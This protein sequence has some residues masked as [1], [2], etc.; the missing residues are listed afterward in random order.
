MLDEYRREY[1]V[2]NAARLR[3]Q[4]LFLSGQKSNLEIAPIYERYSDLFST[5]SINKLKQSLEATPEH[6][7]TERASLNRLLAFAA[8]QFLE[9]SVKQL[10]EAIGDY[11]AAATIELMNREMTFQET[12]A[13]IAAEPDRHE[14]LAIYKK[15]L[16]V[17]DA[18]NHL[19]AERLAKLRE[20][21]RALGYANY[22]SLFEQLR[23]IDYD[24][25]SREAEILL[26]RTESLYLARLDEA[27][28]RSLGIRVEDAERPDCVYFTHM[29]DYE[30]RFPAR[31]LLGV[32]RDT[33]SGLGINV[34]SQKNIAIDSVSRPRKACRAFCLPISVPDDIKL[35]IRLTGGQ[36]DYQ[37]LFHESG[38]AQHYG[39]ASESL[40]PEFKRSGDCALTKTYAFLFNHLLTDSNWLAEFLAFRDN[41]GFIRSAMLARLTTVRRRV[42]KLMCERELHSTEDLDRA[43]EIYAESQSAA[44]KF[45]T[46]PTEFLFELDDAFYSASYLRAWAFEVQL[47][48][49]LKTRF[50]EH[51]WRSARAGNFLKEIWETG[52]RYTADEMAA[53]IG[54]APITFD[55]LI[56][57]FNEAMK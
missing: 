48:D 40:R 22:K 34:S 49:R 44:T 10:T 18:S 43:A 1:V 33:M 35:V 24:A 4:Y 32:Y 56:D 9:N 12:A 26:A 47:R 30:D 23:S 37:S 52:D 55:S 3:E 6:F 16:D 29:S 50:G 13:I 41:K 31:R 15:R 11:E 2:F 27:L 28:K 54:V 57:E 39:W 46:G 38:R 45:K 21:A 51:W 53:Q 17:I 20:A 5:D 42:A 8:E 19:R 36:S 14:R 25:L 7:E